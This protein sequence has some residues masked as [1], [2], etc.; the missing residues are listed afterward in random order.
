MGVRWGEGNRGGC[1]R[2]SSV[3]MSKSEKKLNAYY[4]DITREIGA[5]TERGDM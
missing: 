5:R 1:A 2:K 4:W 3:V